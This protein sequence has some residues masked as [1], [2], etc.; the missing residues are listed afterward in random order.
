MPPVPSGQ[1][2]L[3]CVAVSGRHCI[4][5]RRSAGFCGC[6]QLVDVRCI[7]ANIPGRAYNVSLRLNRCRHTRTR[8]LRRRGRYLL[9]CQPAIVVHEGKGPLVYVRGVRTKA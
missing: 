2:S 8:G 3:P 9:I 1:L 5:H 4:I 6:V 7:L